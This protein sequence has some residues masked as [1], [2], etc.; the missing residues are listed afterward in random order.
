[1]NQTWLN[2][3]LLMIVEWSLE[4]IKAIKL[5]WLAI[6][7]GIKVMNHQLKSNAM[8][9]MPLKCFPIVFNCVNSYSFER[10]M[11]NLKKTASNQ[12]EESKGYRVYPQM[13][14]I[15]KWRKILECR[16]CQVRITSEQCNRM[17]FHGIFWI[18][19]KNKIFIFQ[20]DAVKYCKSLTMI[21]S[22]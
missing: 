19:R 10:F 14:S 11:I 1:M 20:P 12:V 3:W 8:L 15:F 16:L 6:E 4:E 21:L 17:R 18:P 13:E 22:F 2:E 5:Q 9:L 7:F